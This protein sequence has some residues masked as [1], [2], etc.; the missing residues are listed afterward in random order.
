MGLLERQVFAHYAVGIAVAVCLVVGFVHHIDAPLVAEFV[1]VFAVGVVRGA[2]EID[3]R[4]LH[5]S[6]VLLVGGVIHITA[7][8]GMMVV[9]VHA[10]QLHVL[11]VDLEYLAGNFHFLHPEVV[12]EFLIV[13]TILH[14]A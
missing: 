11:A 5:Q 4:L 6:D 9:T 3:V 8:L 1:E 13:L 14:P 12:F 10:A 2:Q 7:R